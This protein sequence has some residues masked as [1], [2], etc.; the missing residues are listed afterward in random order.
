[1]SSKD[2]KD[3][4]QPKTEQDRLSQFI[5]ANKN[6]EAFLLATQRLER[7]EK[8]EL[9]VDKLKRRGYIADIASKQ[10]AE[11]YSKDRLEKGLE[12]LRQLEEEGKIERQQILGLRKEHREEQVRNHKRRQEAAAKRI[13]DT[14]TSIDK[15]K[16]TKKQSLPNALHQH[17]IQKTRSAVRKRYIGRVS[18]MAFRNP[19][20]TNKNICIPFFHIV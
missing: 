8:T 6:T 9:I 3:K 13:A 14:N 17:L 4:Y 19:G 5:E 2:N 7:E 11:K 1:M 15:Q 18:E 12:I 10:K 16:K 20:D